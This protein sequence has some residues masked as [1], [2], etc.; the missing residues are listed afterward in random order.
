MYLGLSKIHSAS[1]PKIWSNNCI[2]SLSRICSAAKSDLKNPYWLIC[3]SKLVI[4][5]TSRKLGSLATSFVGLVK[6]L[7]KPWFM[8]EDQFCPEI[9]IQ[10]PVEFPISVTH[11]S[12]TILGCL[13]DHQKAERVTYWLVF[14]TS[15]VSG[16]LGHKGYDLFC[17]CSDK[18]Q[19]SAAMLIVKIL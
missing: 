8:Q 9:L 6:I 2:V 10:Q 5:V 3:M 14:G 12:L 7:Q 18:S 4:W 11:K 13:I 16:N 15:G 17:R 19:N 1:D